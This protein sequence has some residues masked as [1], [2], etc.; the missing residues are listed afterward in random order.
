[1]QLN[2]DMQQQ[3]MYEHIQPFFR[4]ARTLYWWTRE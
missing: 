3:Y 1:M 2:Q 4:A